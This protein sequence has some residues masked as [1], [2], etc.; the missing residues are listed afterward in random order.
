[1]NN[2]IIST[3]LYGCQS[4]GLTKALVI[5]KTTLQRATERSMLGIKMKDRG[6]KEV[7]NK[8][9][10][11]KTKITDA[12][13]ML[14]ILRRKWTGQSL[15]QPMKGGV[16]VYL[17]L[18]SVGRLETERATKAAVEKRHRQRHEAAGSRYRID[19]LGIRRTVILQRLKFKPYYSSTTKCSQSKRFHERFYF[20]STLVL[21]LFRADDGRLCV[22][23]FCSSSE[24]DVPSSNL[25]IGTRMN[26]IF[27]ILTLA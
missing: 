1:M 15:E 20:K 10:R 21:S 2:T 3:L 22:V 7:R 17:A 27:A 25:K 12:I 16:N 4:W 23:S 9:I 19:Q 8:D 13:I 11:K 5:K 24:L 14:C 6:K 26:S 18:M